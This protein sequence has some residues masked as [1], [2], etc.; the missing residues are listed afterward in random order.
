MAYIN[1]SKA[2]EAI[3]EAVAINDMTGTEVLDLF[4]NY[5]G[6]QVCD[7]GFMEHIE[8]EGYRIDMSDVEED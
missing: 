6:L 2:Y 1:S 7:A 3:S 4:T 5:L 8:N